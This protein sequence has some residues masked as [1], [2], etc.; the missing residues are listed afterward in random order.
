LE[1][2]SKETSI[3]W[4]KRKFEQQIWNPKMTKCDGEDNLVSYLAYLHF[5]DFLHFLAI[6]ASFSL[7][8]K[9]ENERK[10]VEYNGTRNKLRIIKQDL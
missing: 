8:I 9:H 3:F 2:F 6:R 10:M 4:T 7:L 5:L 1:Y